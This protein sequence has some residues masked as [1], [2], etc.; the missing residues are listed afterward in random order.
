MNNSY[1][2]L[3]HIIAI[4][5][6]VGGVGCLVWALVRWLRRSQDAPAVLVTKWLLTAP[7]VVVM[8]FS[9]KWFSWFGPF[10]IVACAIVCSILWAPNIGAALSRPLTS[11]FDGGD[12]PPERRPLYSIARA[13]RAKGEFTHAIAEIRK[14]LALFPDDLEGTMLLAEIQARDCGDLPS[15]EVTIERFCERQGNAS[16]QVAAALH[17]LAD[18]HLDLEQSPEAARRPLERIRELFP[19]TELARQAAERL[20]HLGD[21]Q[22]IVTRKAPDRVPLKAGIENVGL[23]SPAELPKARVA[24]PAEEAGR[25]V[26]QLE[27]HPQD[28][29]ARERL[30][31]LYAE[32]YQRLDLATDQIDTLVRGQSQHPK[33]VA[34]WLNLLAD[35]QV[36]G[37]LDEDTV[38]QTLQTI[39]DL[40]PDHAVADTAQGRLDRLKLELRAKAK[41]QAVTLGSYEKYPGLKRNG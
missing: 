4:A 10:V 7:L 9:V 21:P 28:V 2:L 11:A 23:R 17:Q 29:E 27:R 6:V 39:I 37:G 38:R 16:P 24:D 18:W 22:L 13:R 25:L 40:Y 14:Q 8:L 12:L 33:R 41:S 1:T 30:A 36:R 3:D 19:D 34:R 32:H 20:A 15:A 31:V 5:L 26:R 35:L